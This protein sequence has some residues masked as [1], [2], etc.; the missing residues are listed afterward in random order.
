MKKNLPI[1]LICG[2][3]CSGKSIFAQLFKTAFVL[4][5]DHFYFGKSRLKP[6]KDG[7]Y[8]FDAPEAIDI[9]ACAKAAEVLAQGKS[10]VI[11]K[12]DMKTSER[13]GTQ[14]IRVPKDKKFLI[15]EGIFSLYA[16]LREMGA[17]KIFLDIPT[18]VR[19]ARRMIRD[20]QKGR[21]DIDTLAWSITVEK[22]H[23]LY[24][25]PLKHY[26]DLVI[27]FSYNPVQFLT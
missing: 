12:Y 22:N 18:E 26:A 6:E 27:P 17:M 11:P 1:I 10:A 24:V 13:T 5:M 23:R 9:V 21:S 14:T 3:S 25:D 7:S 4:E 8:N 20:V 2:G 15:V 16:P 19:V